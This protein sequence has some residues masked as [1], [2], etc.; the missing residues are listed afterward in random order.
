MRWFPSGV[1][2]RISQRPLAAAVATLL[3][4]VAAAAACAP[5]AS[6]DPDL[7]LTGGVIYPLDA[8]DDPVPALAIR[9][10]LVLALGDN[11][12]I[13]QLAGRY[14]QQMN[15]RDSV[16]LPGT[17]DAWIDLEALGR[18]SSA[19]LDVRLASSIEEVQAMVRNAADATTAG[20]WIIGW[21]WD[22]ND[23]P[24][25]VLP[26][27]EALDAVTTE[28]PLALLHRHGQSAWLNTAGLAALP[29]A[30]L[31]V[32]GE[33]IVM[34][35]P[36]GQPSGVVA[37]AALEAL[38]DLLSGDPTARAEWLGDGARYAASRGI[39]HA[40]TT[41]VDT[42]TVETLLELEVLGIL[43]LRVDVR[44]TPQAASLYPGSNI[45]RRVQA[46]ALVSVTAVGL[47]LDGP[48]ASRLGAL[49]APYEGGDT[50]G[51]LA[52]DAVIAAAIGAS[53][54][55]GLPL[56]LH[57]SGDRAVIAALDAIA[58][59]NVAGGMIAGFDLLPEEGAS[60]AAGL[61]VA[62]AA[63]RFSSDIYLLDG[64]LGPERAARA[65]AWSDLIAVGV[66]LSFASDAPAYELRPLAA[67]AAV[68]TRQTANGYPA[69]GWNAS[70]TVPLGR[71]VRALIGPRPGG[72]AGLVSG[73]PADLVVWSED[74]LV[75]DPTALRRAEAM[76]TIVAGRVAYSRALVELPMSVEDSR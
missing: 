10:A 31:A 63:A 56:H 50:A 43:P 72:A 23:W 22:E 17:Y 68:L 55:T 4:A 45:E 27:R 35:R 20:D 42:T 5:P 38:T 49:T 16:V 46:S 57:A 64:L 51:L 75:G 1:L 25:P 60:R 70:Q 76:L 21:G 65:H 37:G 24:A 11:D 2:T 8:S 66:S 28:R 52:N 33:G 48:L 13:L 30:T 41:P 12:E 9:G 67:M 69:D 7:I 6:D 15:L 32:G 18:W 39:T 73:G 61:D 36:D 59:T 54:E 34:R 14:T 53:T 19:A 26:D 62:I 58:D 71:L 29:D 44:L 40:G 3:V 47:R 74:P